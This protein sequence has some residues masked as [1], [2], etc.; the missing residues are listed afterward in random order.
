[1]ADHEDGPQK[2]LSF[3]PEETKQSSAPVDSKKAVDLG[4]VG[5]TISDASKNRLLKAMVQR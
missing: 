2:G 1:M 4:P 5:A 3:S